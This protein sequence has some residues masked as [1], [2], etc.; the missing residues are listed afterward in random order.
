[1]IA[2]SLRHPVEVASAKRNPESSTNLPKPAFWYRHHRKIR[3]AP[4]ISAS[5]TE[6]TTD[7]SLAIR[8]RDLRVDYGD[9]HAVRDLNLE[10]PRGEVYGL[11]GPNG[12]GKTST[13]KILATLMEPTYGEVEL[14]GVDA[15]LN[16]KEVRH[17]LAY[18]PDLAPLPSDLKCGEFLEM[19]AAAHGLKGVEKRD[20]I[21]ECLEAVNLLDKRKAFCKTLSRGM[22]QRLVLAKSLLHKPEILI[23]DEPASGLDPVARSGLRKSLRK[24]AEDGRTVIVSSHILSEL[25]DMCTSVGLM[26]NGELVASGPVAD[27]VSK[28]SRPHR[29]V[30]LRFVGSGIEGEKILQQSDRV[31]KLFWKNSSSDLMRFDFEGTPDDQADLI[32]ELI[33]SGCRIRSFEERLSTIEDIFIELSE[34]GNDHDE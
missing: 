28:M 13:F 7:H 4:S 30:E 2:S 25:A 29:Q 26:K 10:V 6:V 16:P 27:V 12:A 15:L 31:S 34:P 33:A 1:V 5:N 23:L 11:V 22:M 3:Y 21:T 18:M 14:C 8:T 24:I 9:T 20:R 32:G 17:Q 19:F